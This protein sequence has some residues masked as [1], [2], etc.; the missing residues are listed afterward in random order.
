MELEKLGKG[1][2]LFE[3][4]GGGRLIVFILMMLKGVRMQ[5]RKRADSW[6]LRVG[7]CYQHGFR[8][9]RQGQAKVHQPLGPRG[10]AKRF[11]LAHFVNHSNYQE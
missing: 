8:D 2:Y 6:T 11:N 1:Q 3:K 7:Q 9:S 4:L 10:R 5:R